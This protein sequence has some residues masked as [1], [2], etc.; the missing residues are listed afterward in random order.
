[1][2]E[3]YAFK[4]LLVSSKSQSFSIGGKA[5]K[6]PIFVVHRDDLVEQVFKKLIEKGFLAVCSRCFS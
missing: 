3:D 4:H 2:A 6:M 5:E 1:M